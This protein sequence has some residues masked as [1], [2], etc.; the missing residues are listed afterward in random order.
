[1]IVKMR[2]VKEVKAPT[3]VGLSIVP[4]YSDEEKEY[5][6]KITRQMI[7]AR[8]Q[9]YQAYP[10]F[11]DMTYNN[12]YVSNAR[13]S[14]SY[15]PPKRNKQDAR[16][17]TGTTEEKSVTLL[18]ALLNFN[19]EPIV[20]PFDKDNVPVSKLGESLQPLIFRSRQ[21]EEAPFDS[22]KML[23]YKELLD[24]G[25]LFTEDLYYEY[26]EIVKTMNVDWAKSVDMSVTWKE[27]KKRRNY[28]KTNVLSGLNV[29]LGNIRQPF[30]VNQPF[31]VTREVMSYEE[32][33]AV[34]SN[35]SRWKY[36]PH[37]LTPLKFDEAS[38]SEP[39]N[40][41]YLEDLQAEMV[42]IVRYQNRSKNEMQ[43]F[44]NGVMMLP[45]GFPLSVMSGV[46][47]YTIGQT[48]LFPLGKYFAYGRGISAKT[49]VDQVLLDELYRLIILK[50]RQSFVPPRA[51]NTGKT[52]NEEMFYPGAMTDNIN[53]NLLP[54]MMDATGVGSAEF[55]AFEFISRIVDNKTVSPVLSG[56]LGDANQSATSLLEAKKN[57]MMKMAVP[58]VAIM[59]W[60][61]S[62]AKARLHNILQHW[63]KK[64]EDLNPL[65][66][67]IEEKYQA[68]FMDTNFADGT[69][70]IRSVEFT[71][72]VPAPEQVDAEN[73]LLSQK[74][75]RP[76]RKSYISPEAIRELDI[77]FYIRVLP[78]E[79]DMD[80]FKR[81]QFI[82]GIQTAIQLFGPQALNQA[83]LKEEFATK[84]ELPR[85]KLF[86]QEMAQPEPLPQMAMPGATETGVAINNMTPKQ[87]PI[88]QR[89]PLNANL[90]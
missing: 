50:T 23:A 48:N 53:P 54:P 27:S 17:V 52:I 32:A 11:N 8:N 89:S 29:Y 36:V 21:Q 63:T 20:E 65:T 43:L 2:E 41:W 47:E 30:I 7:R 82:D 25:T 74:L 33:K 26:D 19:F 75:N 37:N 42:E 70:G 80:M 16:I 45:K 83:W 12:Y 68:F 3:K 9:R 4:P 49:K 64:K 38:L 60:E 34:Y 77:W 13:A 51:N 18:A 62:S 84:Y 6:G 1:M 86:V 56:Q 73:A 72:S 69:T 40:N 88:E 78:A 81:Q 28:F 22:I 58:L 39:Y 24:Q 5:W 46:C 87:I 57:S 61:A 35:W 55:N 15:I 76:V 79:R 66:G 71:D 59:H 44:I 10:E 67:K 85:E 90:Q 14:N 31:V